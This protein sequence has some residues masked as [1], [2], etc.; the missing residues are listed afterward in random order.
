MSLVIEIEI[1]GETYQCFRI[2]PRR[3]PKSDEYW[4]VQVVRAFQGW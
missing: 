2:W 3:R 4:D 1:K